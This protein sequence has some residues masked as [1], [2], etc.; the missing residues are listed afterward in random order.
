[1]P[2]HVVVSYSQTFEWLSVQ[3]YGY[4]GFTPTLEDNTLPDSTTVNPK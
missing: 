2:D 1:M 3:V 4:L